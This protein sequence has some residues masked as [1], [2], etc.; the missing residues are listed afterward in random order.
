[1]DLQRSEHDAVDHDREE[2]IVLQTIRSLPSSTTDSAEIEVVDGTALVATSPTTSNGSTV[3]FQTFRLFRD[4]LEGAVDG[5]KQFV[6]YPFVNRPSS[7]QQAR[8]TLAGLEPFFWVLRILGLCPRVGLFDSSNAVKDNTTKTWNIALVVH[9][10]IVGIFLWLGF[11]STF[12]FS[13][14]WPIAFCA[15]F[16][17]IMYSN[18]TYCKTD[19]MERF[20]TLKGMNTLIQT[21]FLFIGAVNMVVSA[22]ATIRIRPMVKLLREYYSIT[23]AA[24]VQS[25]RKMAFVHATLTVVT[26]AIIG[27]PFTLVYEDM[28]NEIKTEKSYEGYPFASIDTPLVKIENWIAYTKRNASDS[29]AEKFILNSLKYVFR[30]ENF[31]SFLSC[32]AVPFFFSLMCDVLGKE[33]KRFVAF[34]GAKKQ[35][36]PDSLRKV[37]RSHWMLC[38][39][40]G[41]V[42][43]CFSVM[44]LVIYI[45]FIVINS[46]IIYIVLKFGTRATG[47]DRHAFLQALLM[48]VTLEIIFFLVI[49]QAM[50]VHSITNQVI[51]Q[52]RNWQPDMDGTVDSEYK[53]LINQVTTTDVSFTAWNCFRIEESAYINALAIIFGYV[54]MMLQYQPPGR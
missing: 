12:G 13:L 27:I 16:Q 11:V 2:S 37:R 53:L 9:T 4:T 43:E 52:I 31:F 14:A 3:R 23:P 38:K 20:L 24:I 54:L 17:S 48:F 26:A 8:D 7:E 35:L 5:V 1:M 6:E 40:S 41:L 47:Q 51:V 36:T 39:L 44:T 30:V 29:K 49:R 50:R 46:S 28:L 10:V 22:T 19:L 42:D 34:L 25:H 45:M 32:F 18:E 33:W 21:S 15:G